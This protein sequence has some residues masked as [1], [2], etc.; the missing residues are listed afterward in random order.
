M[1]IFTKL[2]TLGI[3]F[4]SLFQESY[5]IIGT[6]TRSYFEYINDHMNKQ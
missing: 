1:N 3:F 4:K 2:A 5:G 6:E